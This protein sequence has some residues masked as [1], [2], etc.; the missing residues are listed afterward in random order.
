MVK[1][2]DAARQRIDQALEL[3][4]WAV[5]DAKSANIYASTGV[6]IREFL[7]NSGHG[8]A[9]YLLYVNGEAVGVVES[10]EGGRDTNRR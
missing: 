9:D 10:Q 7:L 3:A 5:Q 2:E 8:N 6:A 1:P 4:G